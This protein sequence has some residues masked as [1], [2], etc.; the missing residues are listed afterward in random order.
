MHAQQVF[1]LR[2]HWENFIFG[3]HPFA[4]NDD[5][6]IYSWFYSHN[7]LPFVKNISIEKNGNFGTCV[8]PKWILNFFGEPIRTSH[9]TE[10]VKDNPSKSK[11]VIKFRV[12]LKVSKKTVT[13]KK[14]IF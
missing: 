11:N 3:F 5:V 13:C 4:A 1:H 14:Y 10:I 7:Q 2:W 12:C 9:Y 8:S 6:L